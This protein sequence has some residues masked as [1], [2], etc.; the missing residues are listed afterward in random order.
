MGVIKAVNIL[1][2]KLKIVSGNIFLNRLI[3]NSV[4]INLNEKYFSQF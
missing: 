3:N 1:L 4:I 2:K